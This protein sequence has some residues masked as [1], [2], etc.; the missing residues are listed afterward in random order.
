M[1][2]YQIIRKR[3]KFQSGSEVQ[4]LNGDVQLF[5]N[6]YS[7]V[8]HYQ[9]R[10]DNMFNDVDANEI[11]PTS[12][13]SYEN[14][15]SQ[16][17]NNSFNEY[18]ENVVK[19]SWDTLGMAEQAFATGQVPMGN[20]PEMTQSTFESMNIPTGTISTVQTTNMQQSQ[21]KRSQDGN[22]LDPMSM[23]YYSAD[24]GSRASLLGRSIGR[25]G[26]AGDMWRNAKDSNDR[27]LAGT[28]RGANIAQGVFAGLSLGTGLA[29]EIAGAASAERARQKDLMGYREQLQ[30]ERKR[31][32]IRYKEGGGPKTNIGNGETFDTSSLTGEYIYP[33]P[34]SM[35]GSANVEIEKG[36]YAT[37]PDVVGPMEALGERHEKGG[38]PVS[39]PE[40]SHIVSDYRKITPEFATHIRDMYGI[41]VTPKNT[42]ADV[43]DKY[44]NKIGL[45][46]LYDDQEKVLKR[47][48]KNEAVKDK[49]TSDLNKSILSKYISENQSKIDDLEEDF[50]K[51]TDMVYKAQEDS[52]KNEKIE[53]FFRNGGH[54]SLSKIRST[55]KQAGITEAEAKEIIYDEYVRQRRKMAEGGPTKEQMDNAMQQAKLLNDIFGR[56][57]NFG[58]VDVSGRNQILNPDS[59][60]NANQELQSKGTL[61]SYGRA[62]PESVGNLVDVN[63]WAR[64]LSSGNDFDT[65]GFQTGYNRRLNM[66]WALANAGGIRN[67]DAAKDFRSQYGFWGQT[68]V[69]PDG[70]HDPNQA[71]NSFS[72]DDKYGQTTATRSFYSLDV[73]TPE[74]KKLLNEKDIKNYVDLF[75]EKSE[76]AKKILGS[77]Y[78]KFQKMHDAHVFDGIDFVLG[79]YTPIQRNTNIP[80]LL[81]DS[82]P[83]AP[84]PV[85]P[86]L[87]P[88]S[89]P[90]Q[91]PRTTLATRQQV[92]PE[93]NKGR[94]RGAGWGAAGMMFPEVLRPMSSGLIFRGLERHQAPRVS[95]VLESADQYINEMNRVVSSQM[96]ALKDVPDSQRAAILAN[97]QAIAST[98]AGRYINQVNLNNARQIN[99]ADK[100]N[101]T[102][103]VQTDDKNIIERQRY[104]DSILRAMALDEENRAR[105]WDSVNDEVQKKFNVSSSMS[106]LKAIAPDLH[107]LP[108]GQIVYASD[109]DPISYGDWSTPYLISMNDLYSS[110]TTKK[111]ASAKEKQLAQVYLLKSMGLI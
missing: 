36:E 61:F 29:R 38:T 74:Q 17:A 69:R 28:A 11:S 7:Y 13:A 14:P 82:F 98:N 76:E 104:E 56:A 2:R 111:K 88:I 46:E 55:A 41:K 37:R 78:D 85:R 40:G 95:P 81:D 44:K 72:V 107:M 52:K 91:T 94:R 67:S 87:S 26:V 103:Y 96:D 93:G 27:M 8:P 101:E 25:I 62:T 21:E 108:N 80:P 65:E 39:L 53:E 64:G 15:Y 79:E 63:R 19:S 70:T 23:P 45:K 54:I 32:F 18:S 20:V 12:L 66:L 102:A 50:R 97:M 30:N 75:G 57:L 109:K 71:F 34:K 77:D 99:E 47:L 1:A 105:N 33:L 10:Y 49:N 86:D 106:T 43:L 110:D 84:E 31:S 48:E 16:I 22:V 35:E 9:E 3:P 73:L 60:V 51:F 83:S 58:I 100:F 90:G 68:M 89:E 5:S 24:L 59:N 42:Y 4:S 6:P 92:Q